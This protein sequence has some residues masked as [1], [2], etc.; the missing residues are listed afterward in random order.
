[1]A[2]SRVCPLCGKQYSDYPAIS[3]KD[4]RTK[5]CTSCGQAEAWD[6]FMKYVASQ[7]KGPVV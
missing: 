4:N 1:M 2:K 5:I 3:R 7:Q 6:A